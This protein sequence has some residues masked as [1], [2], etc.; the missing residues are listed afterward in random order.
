LIA[1]AAALEAVLLAQLRWPHAGLT[2]FFAAAACYLVGLAVVVRSGGEPKRLRLILLAA[3][4]FR[5]TLLPMLPLQS[6]DLYRTHWDGKV[7][8]AG[9]NPYQYPPGDD[10]FNPIR[11]ANDQLVPAQSLAA[12]RLPLAELLSRWS[13]DLSS[14]IRGEKL[15]FVACDILI[16]LLLVRMLRARQWPDERVLIYA[17]SPLAIF[18]VAGNGHA[19]AAAALLV[20]LA[21]HWAGRRPR[22][23]AAALALGALT[24]WFACVGA[25]AV[26]AAGRRKGAAM[27]AVIALCFVLCTLPY[28]F[29]NKHLALSAIAANMRA[30]WAALAPFN[31][32]IFALAAAWFG[33]R[34]AEAIAAGV[35]IAVM[36][37]SLVQKLEPPRAALVA[38]AALLLVAPEVQPWY[39][40]W[41]LPLLALW[42]E[43]GWIYFSLA[44]PL[45]YL[46]P[47]HAWVVWVEYVPLFAL[48]AWQSLLWKKK[49]NSR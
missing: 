30:H 6:H 28:A 15:L 35:V 2:W 1:S 46:L 3:I 36:I 44:V 23:S 37:R 9:F 16:L 34:A 17:W 18:E 45:A 4:L 43:R 39:V 24:Q 8:H 14:R 42:P 5:L 29:M 27:A 48:M 19:E 47:A 32:S 7:Q 22:W 21:L 33:R 38:V 49:V 41:L 40:L 31:A 25:A 10:L 20:L 12:Y 11:V 13:Y 26:L